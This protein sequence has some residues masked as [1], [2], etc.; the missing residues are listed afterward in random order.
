MQASYLTY[1]ASEIC[2]PKQS[3][4]IL[5]YRKTPLGLEVMLVHPGGPFW[6]RKDQ[7]AWSVP[8]GEFAEPE[9]PF[10]AARRELYE[11]TGAE[12]SGS[13][14]ALKPVRQK[15]G[16]VVHVWAAESNWDVSRLRSNTFRME[17]PPKSGRMAEFPEVDRAEWFPVSTAREKILEAQQPLLDELIEILR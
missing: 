7:G 10:D 5:L 4:G 8:K 17:Y 12:V 13:F 16:K 3:A 2:M 6:A 1:S 11:E 9:A 15:G 14:L